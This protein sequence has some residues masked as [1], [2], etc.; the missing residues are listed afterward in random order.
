MASIT[1]KLVSVFKVYPAFKKVYYIS[2]TLY[3]AYCCH[4]HTGVNIKLPDVHIRT[5]FGIN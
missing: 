1:Y 3:S 4:A 5:L 2:T